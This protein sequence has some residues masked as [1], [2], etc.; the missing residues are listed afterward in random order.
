MGIKV[1]HW[2]FAGKDISKVP[3]VSPHNR[4]LIGKEEKQKY[5]KT[6]KQTNKILSMELHNLTP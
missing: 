5:K 1:I 2:R 4:L 3:K 6:I